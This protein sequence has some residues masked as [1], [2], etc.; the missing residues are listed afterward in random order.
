MVATVGAPGAKSAGPSVRPR[1]A[2][3]G[4]T[5]KYSSVTKAPTSRSALS[6]VFS[7]APSPR[8]KASAS[9]A[10]VPALQSRNVG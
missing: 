7:T 8:T 2:G 10:L 9:K 6:P 5:R 4:R 1:A 3:S